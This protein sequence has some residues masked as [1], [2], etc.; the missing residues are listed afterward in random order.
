MTQQL[1]DEQFWKLLNIY[2]NSYVHSMS[3]D[4]ISPLINAPVLEKICN[5]KRP[6]V[7][8]KKLVK[9]PEHCDRFAMLEAVF[10][11]R[12]GIPLKK[13]IQL[14][15]DFI[16]AD[17]S[18]IYSQ[19][20][21]I[22]DGSICSLGQYITDPGE[23]AENA[24]TSELLIDN[25]IVL[26]RYCQL[27]K[28]GWETLRYAAGTRRSALQKMPEAMRQAMTHDAVEQF[29]IYKDISGKKMSYSLLMEIIERKAVKIFSKLLESGEIFKH[30]ITLEELCFCLA[31]GFEDGTSVPFLQAI[32]NIY[33]GT[34][35]SVHDRWGRNL[36]WYAVL[37]KKTAWF[38]PFCRLTE[39]LI[40]AGCD[41]NNRNQLDFSFAELYCNLDSSARGNILTTRYLKSAEGC[42]R[43]PL[44]NEQPHYAL[45]DPTLL[46]EWAKNLLE[47][48]KQ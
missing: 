32:E 25:A 22:S 27:Q 14:Y 39:F 36:L 29:L 9:L 21:R 8:L 34:V 26:N 23:I 17:R 48:G 31:G 6:G 35:K 15:T 12:K 19:E 7:S 11:S 44:K 2:R 5:S 1:I 20:V 24:I 37:N 47:S 18:R 3:F 28:P 41:V 45:V 33:P 16:L 42:Y 40:N 4:E 30:A 13:F 46:P 10:K 38:H 43:T